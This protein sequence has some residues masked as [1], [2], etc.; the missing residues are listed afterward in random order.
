VIT[1]KKT[2]VTKSNRRSA[3]TSAP[4]IANTAIPK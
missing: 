4:D 3:A 2:K 1:A